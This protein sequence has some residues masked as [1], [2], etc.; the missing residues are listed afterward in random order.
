MSS[1]ELKTYSH[2]ETRKT[3][4]VALFMLAKEWKQ[5]KDPST[6]EQINKMWHIYQW[7]ITQP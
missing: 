4:M 2:T 1:R 6:T 7:N 3:F 5:P